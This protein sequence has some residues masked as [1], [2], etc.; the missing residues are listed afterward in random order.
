MKLILILEEKLISQLNTL[1]IQ[2]ACLLKL[3][4][5]LN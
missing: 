4:D 1:K 2:I 3:I 5:A